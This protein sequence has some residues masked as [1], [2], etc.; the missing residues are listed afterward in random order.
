MPNFVID[1]NVFISAILFSKSTPAQAINLANSIGK[2]ILSSAIFI[3]IES[4]LSRPKFDRYLSQE[5][6]SEVLSKLLL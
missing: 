5:K 6:R 2:I 1:T 4:T 3:E